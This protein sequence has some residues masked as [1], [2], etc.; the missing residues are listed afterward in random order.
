[1]AQAADPGGGVA[2]V[3]APPAQPRVTLQI[4][5]TAAPLEVQQPDPAPVPVRRPRLVALAPAPLRRLL[6]RSAH[7]THGRLALRLGSAVLVFM[8]ITAAASLLLV[9][10]Y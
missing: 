5:R 1:M 6:Q 8:G 7:W 3:E 10:V 2:E 9:G 4:P